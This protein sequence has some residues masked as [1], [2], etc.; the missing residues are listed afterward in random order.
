MNVLPNGSTIP[1][2]LLIVSSGQGVTGQTPGVILQKKS[3]G[4]YWTGSGFSNTIVIVPLI[5]IDSINRPGYYSI[6]FNQSVDPVLSETYL[7]YF[8][9]TGTYAGVAVDEFFFNYVNTDVDPVEIG[10]VVASFILQDPTTPIDNDDI[11]S[12]TTLLDVENTV[13]NISNVM[14]LQST[15]VSFETSAEASLAEILSI[16]Q[17]I[18]GANQITFNVLDQNSNPVPG[19]QITLKNTTSQI[20]LAVGYTNING[21]L[22]LGLPSGTYNVLLF[23]AFYTFGTQPISLV[24]TTN[25]S[26][27]YNATSFVPASVLPNMCTVFSYV[28]DATGLPVCGIN[29]RMK[30]VL[31]LP[32]ASTGSSL[33]KAGW[34]ETSTD[35]TGY[36]SL[37]AIQGATVEVSIPALQFS[38]TNYL[39]PTQSSLDLSTLTPNVN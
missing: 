5:E 34:V 15:L 12:Q 26:V 7:A 4:S 35:A 39:I 32:F 20:T 27:T 38:M 9:N 13:D 31:N 1:L 11:A 30:M 18:S 29:V 16:L 28:L 17:P 3:T 6:T 25:Q 36:W 10:K 22:V 37:Q 21:Q 19:V 24:V 33:I 2:D 8:K 23:K 14:A